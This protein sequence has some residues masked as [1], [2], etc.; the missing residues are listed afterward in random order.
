MAFLL[1]AIG[2]ISSA[3][4]WFL[5]LRWPGGRTGRVRIHIGLLLI[6]WFFLAFVI[7]VLLFRILLLF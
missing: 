7:A 1:F 5:F 3:V 6:G 4:L 2:G